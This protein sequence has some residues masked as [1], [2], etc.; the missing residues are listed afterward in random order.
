MT[1][2]SVLGNW[3]LLAP[4][5]LQGDNGSQVLPGPW[6]LHHPLLIYL[7]PVYTSRL[8]P[9]RPKVGLA[10]GLPVGGAAPPLP[11]ILR[12]RLWLPVSGPAPSSEAGPT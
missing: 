10:P 1:T 5:V 4:P 7:N 3:L 11:R 2:P 12:P 9:A 6:V 8:F